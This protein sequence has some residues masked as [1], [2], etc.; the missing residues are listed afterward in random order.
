MEVACYL[1]FRGNF[2]NI[3]CQLPLF[4]GVNENVPVDLIFFYKL[5]ILCVQVNH[6]L[7]L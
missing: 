1:D 3:V 4:L 6:N 5:A 7:A 2:V